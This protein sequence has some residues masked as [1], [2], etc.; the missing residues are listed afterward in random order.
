[1]SP[2]GKALALGA[3]KPLPELFEAA[4]AR[5]A[6]DRPIVAELVELIESELAKLEA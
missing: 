2:T 5:F 1:M 4:G 6:F 3:T